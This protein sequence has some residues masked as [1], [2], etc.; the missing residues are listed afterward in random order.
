MIIQ[1]RGSFIKHE[2]LWVFKQSTGNRYP[3]SLSAGE[4]EPDVV[5]SDDV[6]VLDAIDVDE[7][8]QPITSPTYGICI[9][10]EQ[11]ME[12]AKQ[13]AGF[14]PAEADDLRKAIGKKIHELMASLKDKFIEGCASNDVSQAVANQLW[15]DMEQA[16]DYSFNKSHAACYALI[17]YRTA[18]L[19]ANYPAEYMAALISSV[20]NTKDRVPFYV[21]ACEEMGIEVLPPDVNVSAAG[22]A[23]VEGKIRFGLSAVKNVGDAAVDAIVTARE[24]DGPIASIWSFCERVDPQVANKR[25]LESL[26]KAGVLDATGDSR[27]GMLSVLEAALASGN[28]YHADRLTGQGSIF[29]LDGLGDEQPGE[30]V[31]RTSQHQP[32]PEGEFERRELLSL[33]KEALGLYVSEHPLSGLAAPLRRATD[34]PV[35][36]LERR[37]DGEVVTVAGMVGTTRTL[38][39][40]KG[41]PMAFV[42]I[43][44][45]SGSAEAMLFNS[46]YSEARE[47]IASDAILLI[48]GRV[49]H[50][51]GE[52]KLI[53]LEVSELEISDQPNV[54]RLRVDAKL[55]RV[56][57]IKELA[58]VVGDFPGD[59]PVVLDLSTGRGA[60]TFELGP[61]YR[62]KPEADFFAE[63]KRLLGEAAVV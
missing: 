51:D 63:V 42:R 17:A 34:C 54:V 59:S 45:L 7:R 3:L 11:Y 19:K 56:D 49:D 47:L 1:S 53:A 46:V 29:D 26:V 32:V 15:K 18:Y 24:K 21:Q 35:S 14:S 9:Y 57:L 39:T 30:P 61:A 27:Q 48:R 6:D 62:V 33:E 36:E 5:V 4:R 52:V 13:L 23:V 44:D 40:R 60:R 8:L 20:M 12:I 41:D 50:K 38:T 28:R 2:N 22:F 43:D 10:Q 58:H 31:G 16:Q 37:R 55:A 25:A